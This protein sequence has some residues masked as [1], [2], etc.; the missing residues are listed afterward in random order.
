MGTLCNSSC[1][2]RSEEKTQI[3]EITLAKIQD[4]PDNDKY[5]EIY[6]TDN[7]PLPNLPLPPLSDSESFY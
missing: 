5:K 7:S 4:M 3:E 2:A 1:M 6:L